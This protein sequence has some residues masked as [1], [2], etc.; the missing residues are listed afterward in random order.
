VP[1]EGVATCLS[2]PK[3]K[4]TKIFVHVDSTT[5]LFL[6]RL[7]SYPHRYFPNAQLSRAIVGSKENLLIYITIILV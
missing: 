2:P 3:K 7:G 1:V 6:A 5:K 4:L